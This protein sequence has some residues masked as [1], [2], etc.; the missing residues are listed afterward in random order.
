M[1]RRCEEFLALA[2]RHPEFYRAV[3]ERGILTASFSAFARL[4]SRPFRAAA[5]QSG[6]HQP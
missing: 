1:S 5:H 6:I 2:G 4:V 3:G